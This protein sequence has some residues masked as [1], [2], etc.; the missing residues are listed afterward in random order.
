[1]AFMMDTQELKP[2]LVIFRRADVKHRRWY[3]RIR[4]RGSVR[5]KTISLQTADAGEAR[6]RAYD[7]DADIRF[8]IKHD[9]PVFSRKFGEVAKEYS[10][11]HKARSEIE[12]ITHHRWRVID[13][14][15]R[16]QLNAYVGSVQITQIGQ[17][18]WTSYPIWRQHPRHGPF[19][20]Q[21][22]RRHHP[23]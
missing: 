4:L 18:R 10:D 1:M 11:F 3:A 9:V 21:G 14:H 6:D 19:R 7:H 17:D 13:S 16:I 23:R 12:Q 5:Y 8:R 20:R 22:E 2:G 15:I